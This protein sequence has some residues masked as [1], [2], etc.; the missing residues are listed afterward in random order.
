MNAVKLSALAAATMAAPTALEGLAGYSFEQYVA[1]FS[2]QYT[3]KEM[4]Q[5]EALFQIAHKNVMTHNADESHGW[6]MALNKFSDMTERELSAFK[7]KAAGQIGPLVDPPA[8][9]YRNLKPV[10]ELPA[11]VDWREKGVVTKTKDQK[12]CGSCWAFS[13]TEVLESHVAIETGKLLELSPQQ[14]VSCAPNPDSCG[15]TGGCEGSV[16]WLG[17]NYTINQGGLGL[18]TD[19]PYNGRDGTCT[20]GIKPAAGITGYVRLPAND[21]TALMNA[22]ATIGPIAISVDAGWQA[23]SGGVWN[24]A[25]GGTCGTTI[26]H[27]VVLVGY[28]TDAKGGDYYLVRNSW[29]ERWGE[30]GYIR[31]HR[32]DDDSNNC[33]TDKNPAD[34]TTCKPYPKTQEVCGISGIL[35]D[36]SYPTGGFVV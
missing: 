22:V 34:G 20:E 28:G 18:E 26:D 29:G 14:L 5:R 19:Y 8:S 23:Y 13:A 6:K 3:N 31:L 1:E 9:F 27:A 16:Q 2:K 10:S 4:S 21:Y 15:G 33:G 36:S 25:K 12:Q 32:S 7:G 30:D 11:S 17:F 35:S 24:C